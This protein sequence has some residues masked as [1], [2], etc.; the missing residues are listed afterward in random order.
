MNRNIFNSDNY[1]YL[2][3]LLVPWSLGFG[4]FMEWLVKEGKARRRGW[5]PAST[6]LLAVVMT[7]DLL[8]WYARF[9]WV[10][11]R[12]R[13]VC[14]PVDDPA[15]AWLAA[16]PDVRW[17]EGGY[18]DVYRLSF[19]TG[20]RVTGQAVRDLSGPLPGVAA[21]AGREEGDDRPPDA[22]GHGLRDA[23]LVSGSRTVLRA[24]G[25]TILATP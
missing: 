10:D 9:G 21:R 15:L 24:R 22:R 3:G 2:V 20:G 8:R 14:K 7:V 11:E 18:W 23:A 19:L 4:L 12:G 5:R 17:I 1:R 25:L 6:V 16:H 13:P